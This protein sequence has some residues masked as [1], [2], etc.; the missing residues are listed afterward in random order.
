MGPT[1]AQGATGA[2]GAKGSTGS[3]G[4]DGTNGTNGS[5][6]TNGTNGTNG[7]TGPTGVP[8]TGG[9]LSGTFAAFTPSTTETAVA[10]INLTVPAGF[11]TIKVS[12]ENDCY[13]GSTIGDY[14]VGRIRLNAGTYVGNDAT[15]SPAAGIP[16]SIMCSGNQSTAYWHSP[17]TRLFTGVASG[18]NT[19]TLRVDTSSALTG[20]PTVNQN[21]YTIDY[22]P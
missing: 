13:A 10:T 18:A 2:T 14:V 3:T 11:T 19:I 6:G 21:Y 7:A 5:N 8:G 12:W 16:G 22:L 1:G 15:N 17:I 9:Q 20:A 4:A